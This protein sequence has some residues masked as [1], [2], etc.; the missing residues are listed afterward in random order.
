MTEPKP[1]AQSAQAPNAREQELLRRLREGEKKYQQKVNEAEKLRVKLQREEKARQEAEG[2]RG[3]V[4]QEAAH[5]R[6]DL[7]QAHKNEEALRDELVKVQGERSR[8]QEE[9][10]VMK[11]R[12]EDYEKRVR[13]LEARIGALEGAAAQREL[14]EARLA[15]LQRFKEALPEP[16]PEEALLRV[17]VLDYPSLGGRAEERVTA[18]IEG[19]RAFLAGENHPALLH[20]NRDLLQCEAE[21]IV[22]VGLERLLLDLSELPLARWL[23]THAFRLETLLQP[24]P[25]PTSPRFE[26]VP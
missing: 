14:L 13:E 8:L 12:I 11:G 9:N 16:F 2:L 15:Q 10:E 20:S 19:Y 1:P 4:E 18:L 23:R 7:A 21:G 6:K 5:L 25:R 22:L 26:E 24:G 17:L 3:R